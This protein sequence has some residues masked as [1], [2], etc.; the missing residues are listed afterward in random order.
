MRALVLCLLCGVLTGCGGQVEL[1]EFEALKPIKGTVTQAG[2]PVSG[3]VIVFQSEPD[4]PDFLVNSEVGSDGSYTLT[5]VRLNDRTGE[6]KPGAPAGNYRVT[7]TPVIQD[8]TAQGA[9]GPI[10]LPKLVV[11]D[12]REEVL[13]IDLPKKR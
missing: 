2:Q 10:T 9:A 11:I 1:A 4:K 6:R 8:Q 3:G 7:Y 13:N 12:G 5:T